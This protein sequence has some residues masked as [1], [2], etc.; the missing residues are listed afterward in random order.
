MGERRLD[1]LARGQIQ[2]GPDSGLSG[3]AVPRSLNR[4]LRHLSLFGRAVVVSCEWRGWTG[5][6]VARSQ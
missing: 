1:L 2:D 3:S 4:L 5:A 6:H